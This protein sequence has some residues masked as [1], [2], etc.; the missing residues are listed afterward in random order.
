MTFEGNFDDWG[1][2]LKLYENYGH[3]RFWGTDT[4]HHKDYTY[5][6]MLKYSNR[7]WEN[8][9]LTAGIDYRW[10]EGK[11]L[12]PQESGKWEKW[13][14]AP[15]LLDEYTFW[16]SLI[17]SLGGR[18]N[19]DSVYGGA[20]CPHFGAVYHLTEDTSFRGAINKAFRSPQL[21]E[22]Y[23]FPPSTT[24]LDPEE[25]WNY[26][27]GLDQRITDW[28]VGDIVFFLMEGDN[29]IEART[30]PNPPPYKKFYNTGEFSFHGMELGLD[31]WLGKGFSSK[32]FYS[33]LDCG[34]KTAGR[35]ED[36]FDLIFEYKD[37]PF[38]AYL[39]GQFVAGLYNDNGHKDKLKDY[40]V[41]NAKVTYWVTD[42]WQ[43]FFAVDNIF[44]EK[45]EIEKD[46][47]LPG[48]TF[49]GGVKARF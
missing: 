31:F 24:D 35:P 30:N 49:T 33:Y 15:Y 44:N 27:I 40:F 8:N 42:N 37:G 34:S 16:D 3:H 28:L 26:E 20:F 9:E 6:T 11:R 41:A 18:Y 25:L 13:E 21:N 22:L 38:G 1:A 4:W 10:Q 29:L 47:P 39:N 36:K 7:F 2:S 17:L 14:I 45:Y 48:T 43:P 23:M 46:Y 32:F 5:G 12:P 19:H